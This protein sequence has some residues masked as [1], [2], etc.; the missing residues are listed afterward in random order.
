[1]ETLSCRRLSAADFDSFGVPLAMKKRQLPVQ[2][3]FR[4]FS[5]RNQRQKQLAE[6]ALRGTEIN[7]SVIA[8]SFSRY[9]HRAVLK[10]YEDQY[11]AVQSE[12]GWFR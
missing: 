5:Q 4:E 3:P 2:L 1:V 10:Q 8:E 12:F 9:D 6:D 11:V 7:S